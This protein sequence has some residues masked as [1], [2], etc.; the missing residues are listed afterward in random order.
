MPNIDLRAIL[1]TGVLIGA[2]FVGVIAGAVVLAW[3]HVWGW[4]KPLLHAATA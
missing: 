3:P 2:A 4:I 1:I